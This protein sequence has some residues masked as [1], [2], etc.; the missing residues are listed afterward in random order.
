MQ[1]SAN[2]GFPIPDRGS[3]N[4]SGIKNGETAARIALKAIDSALAALQAGEQDKVTNY[5]ANGAITQKDGTVTISKGSAAAMTLADPATPADDG[6]KLSIISKTAF[7]HVVTSAGGYFGGANH[8][9]TFGG[10]IGDGLHLEAIAG[11]WYE[12]PSTNITLS[13]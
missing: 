2:L 8:T 10:T 5:S 6:K 1:T 12:L 11:K 4:W 9:A 7:A 13:T 3:N